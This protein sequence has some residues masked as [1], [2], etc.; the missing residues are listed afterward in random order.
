VF[1]GLEGFMTYFFFRQELQAM[2]FGL[3]L[4]V[5]EVVNHVLTLPPSPI[6]VTR[7]RLPLPSQSCKGDGP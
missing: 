5:N 4:I 1:I 6:R 3:G 2:F 7:T